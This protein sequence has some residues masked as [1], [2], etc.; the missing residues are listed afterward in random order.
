M[1]RT[2][3]GPHVT[4]LGTP[5]WAT[6]PPPPPRGVSLAAFSTKQVSADLF[7]GTGSLCTLLSQAGDR[8][9]SS[10]RGMLLA[11]IRV[12]AKESTVI[13]GLV[14]RGDIVPNGFGV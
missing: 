11:K 4:P 2:C 8:Q 6:W 14:G 3:Q 9:A 5:S 1:E 10:G 12:S 7:P 13:S